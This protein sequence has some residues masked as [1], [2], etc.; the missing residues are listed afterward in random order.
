MDVQWLTT[1]ISALD[2]CFS[3]SPFP[4][5]MCEFLKIL[6]LNRGTEKFFFLFCQKPQVSISVGRASMP[7]SSGERCLCVWPNICLS[8]FW[9]CFCFYVNFSAKFYIQVSASIWESPHFSAKL[10][11]M[12]ESFGEEWMFCVYKNEF[13]SKKLPTKLKTM[14]EKRESVMQ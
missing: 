9:S 12:E 2:S 3:V 6:F 10:T 14:N 8:R 4:F 11:Y 13:T 5:R 7:H 1:F